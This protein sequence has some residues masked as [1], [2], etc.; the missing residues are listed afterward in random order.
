M[1]LFNLTFSIEDDTSVSLISKRLTEADI[2]ALLRRR[3]EEAA[4]RIV[5]AKWLEKRP[6][7]VKTKINLD[8][9]N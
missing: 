2:P 4:D 8:K 5:K 3:D 9:S 7:R 6:L 1:W